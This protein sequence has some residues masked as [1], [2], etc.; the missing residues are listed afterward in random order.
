MQVAGKIH[1][2]DRDRFGR[3]AVELDA[4]E[5]GLIRCEFPREAQTQIDRLR[6][7][8]QVTIRGR[9]VGL[10]GKTV[11]IESCLLVTRGK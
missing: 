9:C 6:P 11:K 8:Q 10:N 5:N 1:R 4:P 3:V 7:D 2:V